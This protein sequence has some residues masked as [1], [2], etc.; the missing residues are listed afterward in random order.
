LAC[1]GRSLL[2]WDRVNRTGVYGGRTRVGCRDGSY[3]LPFR[4]A[5]R[6]L[7]FAFG[8][9]LVFTPARKRRRRRARLN[10]ERAGRRG[11]QARSG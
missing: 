10:R 1:I 5:H 4:A 11:G 9:S 2:S 6:R 7:W 8:L 3:G